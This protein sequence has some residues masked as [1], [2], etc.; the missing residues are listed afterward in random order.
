M[1]LIKSHGAPTTSTVGEVGQRYLDL[2]TD[3]KYECTEIQRKEVYGEG[4]SIHNDFV[5]TTVLKKVYNEYTWTEVA[6]S[7]GTSGSGGSDTY[8][9]EWNRDSNEVLS[10]TPGL[11]EAIRKLFYE[12][13][14]C[15]VVVIGFDEDA[16]E[17]SL[18]DRMEDITLNDADGY[19]WYIENGTVWLLS[20]YPDNSVT[21]QYDE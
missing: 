6:S 10:V 14:P 21:I 19:H 18:F 5:S 4:P 15:K 7:G 1:Y 12:H 13:V 11:Y 16:E 8:I 3:I 17:I 2:D 20:L 9:V